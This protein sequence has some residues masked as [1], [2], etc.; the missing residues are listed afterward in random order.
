MRFHCVSVAFLSLALGLG[1]AAAQQSHA[2]AA[3]GSVAAPSRVTLTGNVHPLTRQS[4]DEGVVPASTPLARMMLVL[5]RSAER[6]AALD[7]L[8]AAQQDPTSPSYHQ[9]LTPQAFGEQFG[10]SDAD[11]AML[12]SWLSRQGF[13]SVKVNAARTVVEFSGTESALESAFN[14]AVHNY[15]RNGSVYTANAADPQVPGE[16]ASLVG[17][18]VSLNNFPRHAN[19]SVAGVFHHDGATGAN[20]RKSSATAAL[21]SQFTLG[22]E[23]GTVY[24]ITP[25][26]FAAI[27]DLNP[28]LTAATP[29]DGTGQTLAIVGETD[30]DPAD[31]IAFRKLFGLPLGNT[32]TSTGTQFLNIIY[33]GPNPGFTAD[34]TEADVDTQWAAAVARGAVIDY[35]ASASTT[36]S[37]GVDLSAEYIVDNNLAPVMSES[38]GECELYL[39]VAGNQ[40]YNNLW[41]QAAAQGITVMVSSG[42]AGAAGCD[43]AGT[44]YAIHGNAVNGLGSTPWNVSVG[45]TDF[46]MPSGGAAYFAST[47]SATFA[48]ARGYIPEL[49]WNNS[50][51]NPALAEF[52]LFAGQ[53]PSALCNSS[54]ASSDGLLSV[55]GGGGGASNCVL[56]NSNSG[57]NVSQ[58]CTGYPKPSWQSVPG[59]PADGVRDV[60][61]VSLF[62]SDGFFGAFYVVCQHDLTGGACS[63]TAPSYDFVGLGGTSVASPA[64]AGIMA[65]V[66]Q[67]SGVR[68]GNANVVLYNLFARQAA[69]GMNCS[70][71]SPASTCLFHDVTSGSNA[72]PCQPGTPDCDAAPGA[73]HGV[74]SANTATQG[75]DTASGLGS[76]DAANL[77]NQ[78]TAASFA[79]TSTS[80]KLASATVTHGTPVAATVSVAAASGSGNSIPTGQVALTT[81]TEPGSIASGALDA[82]GA[83]SA[84][85]ASFP[86]GT[87]T[88]HAHYPGDSNF[89]ASDSSPVALTVTP[90]ASSLI[91]QPLL[92]SYRTLQDTPVTGTVPYGSVNLLRFTV[93]GNSGQ[94]SPT[95]DLTLTDN[96]L[97]LDGGTALLATGGVVE[98]FSTALNVGTHVL[99]AAYAGD[100]SFA[101]SAASATVV[102]TQAPTLASAPIPFSVDPNHDLSLNAAVH[103]TSFGYHAPT[104]T[105]T[106][107]IGSTVLGTA[108]VTE[109]TDPATSYDAGV[110]S[111]VIPSSSLPS[112]SFTITAAYSGDANYAALPVAT[113]F[114]ATVSGASETPST[115]TL[116]VSTTAANGFTATATVAPSSPVPQGQLD[117]YV[118]GVLVAFQSLNAG[119]ASFTGTLTGAG[120]HTISALYLGQAPY[121]ASV[122]PSVTVTVAGPSVPSTTAISLP[123]TSANLGDS[124]LV[125]A[126]VTPLSATGTVRLVVDG[127]TFGQ[128]VALSGGKAAVPFT[129]TGLLPGTHVVALSYSGDS[130][131]QP[132]ASPAVNLALA[133][134]GDS[135]QLSVPGSVAVARGTTSAPAT[136]ALTPSGGFLGTVSLACT[137]LPA[138]AT[139][140]FSQS[141]VSIT[142][143]AAA[144]T[145]IVFATTA[146]AVA[147]L[148]PW[149]GRSPLSAPRGVAIAFAATWLFFVLSPRRRRLAQRLTLPLVLFAL[150]AATQGLTGCGSGQIAAAT[151]ST[152]TLNT[153]TPAG[154]YAITLMARSGSVSQ[155][156]TLTLIVQ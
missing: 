58:N 125:A 121:A 40:F 135:F 133:S 11:L 142:G 50:C 84:S 25:G 118:D 51:A 153:G 148:R 7:K 89:A 94:G 4:V 24:G 99:H 35:V 77:V 64:F 95:G 46:N 124:L 140:S 29:T 115:T 111:L 109:S 31:F 147:S 92:Y 155:T 69:S 100:P 20:V 130:T 55:V 47:N 28:L 22:T 15:R 60:P 90:E 137:G 49:P 129:T 2:V 71:A 44:Q 53:T 75:Y 108:P 97:P 39:G 37:Q 9:W 74:L 131:V 8:L 116:H 32:A 151:A 105:M 83:Y 78:W 18:I 76:V 156:S 127:N 110:A 81:N 21:K 136:V 67:R 1:Q 27:Y 6:Q 146:P 88:V 98:D 143:P 68:Q 14:T 126:S 48:S 5:S 150:V 103:T 82:T 101:A 16:L 132:S 113:T 117:F 65:M 154:S 120:A 3:Q 139:C 144:V 107:S 13:T 106:F 91:I 62:A 128:P 19:Y 145:S 33:N 149:P 138:G 43:T 66:N 141:S 17:G 10:A 56:A 42:D 87:Y 54:T 72:E 85:I 73:A 119:S 36:V 52:S 122:A 96:G 102:V 114:T 30:I 79:P 80:L 70:S 12:T 45:G 34:E 152:T 61:D 57:S 104:G 134:S 123:Q 63:L 86:G 93:A 38:Y 26:D 41:Q 23:N 59:V 112:G